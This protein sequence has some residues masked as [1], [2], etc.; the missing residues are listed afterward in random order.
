[1]VD[2]VLGGGDRALDLFEWFALRICIPLAKSVVMG[3]IERI[4]CGD[5]V[6]DVRD[7]NKLTGQR[8]NSPY[9]RCK[10]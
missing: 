2:A 3:L 6:E 1:M 7:N 8:R 5:G 9:A 4:V 10:G